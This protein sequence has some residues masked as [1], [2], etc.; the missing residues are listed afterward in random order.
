MEGAVF[1][2]I[3]FMQ[4]LNRGVELVFNTDHKKTHWGKH[5]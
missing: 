5:S 4:A 2:Q 1:A 3:G